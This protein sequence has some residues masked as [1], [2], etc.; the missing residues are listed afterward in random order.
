MPVLND[1]L[2]SNSSVW[3]NIKEPMLAFAQTARSERLMRERAAEYINRLRVIKHTVSDY[4]SLHPLWENIPSVADFSRYTLVFQTLMDRERD[5]FFK[6]VDLPSEVVKLALNEIV[7]QW[8]R[9]MQW[10]LYTMIPDEACPEET[11]RAIKR[12]A[13]TEG[14]TL[15]DRSTESILMAL[16][17]ATT[18][19]RCTQCDCLLD[20]PR[21]QA[22]QCLRTGPSINMDPKT[23]ADD[24]ANAYNIVL[25]E[26]PWNYS[27]DK[28]FYDMDA[29][30]AAQK[31][32]RAYT[33]D[34]NVTEGFDMDLDSPRFACG[35]CSK[36]GSVCVMP[37]RVAVRCGV[38]L[39]GMRLSAC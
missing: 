10:R 39:I 18:W 9:D 3:N 14:G 28:I 30:A 16:L 6:E 13:E 17:R 32:V 1:P 24:R 22:H 34:P 27:G 29:R 37:W 25:K 4:L 11:E 23:D 35:E 12:A 2:S 36:N 5:V 33:L 19:F 31:V 8:R 21:V 20:Y 38:F 26:F 7:R 15:D